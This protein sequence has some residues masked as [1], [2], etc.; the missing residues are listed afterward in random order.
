MKKMDDDGLI[1][2]LGIVVGFIICLL[3]TLALLSFNLIGGAALLGVGLIVVAVFGGFI[4][5]LFDMFAS[6][7]SSLFGD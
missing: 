7:F 4:G 1:T 2:L 5:E 6:I 3:G